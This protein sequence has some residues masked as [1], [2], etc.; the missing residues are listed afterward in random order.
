MGLLLHHRRNF[1]AKITTLSCSGMAQVGL[2]IRAA[3][4]SWHNRNMVNRYQPER[5]Y[6]ELCIFGH[7]V[8]VDKEVD[9]VFSKMSLPWDRPRCSMVFCN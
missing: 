2:P 6:S 1:G 4:A 8:H 5:I 9:R 7:A 3:T